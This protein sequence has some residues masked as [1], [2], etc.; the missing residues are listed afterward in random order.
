MSLRLAVTGHQPPVLGGF[1]PEVDA[2][3]TAL[4]RQWLAENSV[5][6]V[7]S[8][9]APGWDLATARAALVLD[10]P[11]VA[12]LAWPEQGHHWPPAA[13]AELEALH[14]RA[15][16]LHVDAPDQAAASYGRRD[17]WVLDRAD[18]VLALWS[19]VPGGTGRAVAH[20]QKRGL[21]VVNLWDR[22]EQP[23]Q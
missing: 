19:G 23:T 11:L 2:A 18:T 7:I 16:E 4:A 1:R 3:L 22:W 20:A 17:R 14:A 5:S 12:A 10:I 6:E 8:G 21:P 9:M 15:A 13:R